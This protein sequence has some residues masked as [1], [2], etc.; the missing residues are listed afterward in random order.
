MKHKFP[1]IQLLFSV[2]FLGF[3]LFAFSYFY[4][5]INNNNIIAQTKE[6]EWQAEK[7]RREEMDTLDRSVKMIEKDKNELE[8]HFARSSDIV[9]F[10][11]F[12]EGLAPKASVKAEVVAVDISK[13]RTALVVGMKASGTFNS[14]YKFL[15]LLEN[16]PYELE[17]NTTEIHKE[18]V[19]E[20]E[21][22]SITNPNWNMMFTFK[23]LSF[24]Q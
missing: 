9:P 10:L 3:L 17:F 16:S 24:V 5:A 14:L 22:K 7:M 1:V 19:S 8:T 11:D 23:L 21:G 13:D 2:I 12:I 15:T 4:K 6:K 20:V 18:G